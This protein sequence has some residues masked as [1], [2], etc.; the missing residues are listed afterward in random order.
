MKLIT[1]R[2][3]TVDSPTFQRSKQFIHHTKSLQLR[4]LNSLS[5]FFNHFRYRMKCTTQQQKMKKIWPNCTKSTRRLRNKLLTI[6]VFIQNLAPAFDNFFRTFLH[7]MKIPHEYSVSTDDLSGAATTKNEQSA[8]DIH[9]ESPTVFEWFF[10]LPT[11]L[12]CLCNITTTS[13]LTIRELLADS[14]VYRLTT[15]ESESVERHEK[16]Q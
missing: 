3:T 7:K 12:L 1:L 13:Y 5:F 10:Q 6:K 11:R 15:N 14:R 9:T 8:H 16:T 4:N 2:K